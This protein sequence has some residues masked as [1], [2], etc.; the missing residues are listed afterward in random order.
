MVWSLHGQRA[1]NACLNFRE[2][3]A[4]LPKISEEA[5]DELI[6]RELVVNRFVL[7]RAHINTASLP[8]LY[9]PASRKF[10][11]SGA[12]GVRVNVVAPRELARARQTLRYLEIATDNAEDDLR[13]QLLANRN[14]TIF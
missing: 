8:K 4:F 7:S 9:P 10:A 13:H 14:F 6:E 2:R 12:H 3:V 1:L 11:I 5:R